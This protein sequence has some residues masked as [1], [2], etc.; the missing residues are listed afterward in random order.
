METIEEYPCENKIEAKQREQYWYNILNPSLN[1]ILPYISAEDI[2]V[3]RNNYR[4]TYYKNNSDYFANYAKEYSNKFPEKRRKI[5]MKYYNANRDKILQQ[6]KEH[7]Y[8]C[9]CGSNIRFADKSKHFK[10]K[11]HLLFIKNNLSPDNIDV[12][13]EF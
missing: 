10:S 1:D 3:K 4:K 9:V 13:N 11:A 5:T 7:R 8:D 12:P 2:K 6:K